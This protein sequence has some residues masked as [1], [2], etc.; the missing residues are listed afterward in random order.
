MGVLTIAIL[1][2][3]ITTGAILAAAMRADRWYSRRVARRAA[4]CAARRVPV[5]YPAIVREVLPPTPQLSETCDDTPA[6]LLDDSF[7]FE[8]TAALTDDLPWDQDRCWGCAKGCKYSDFRALDRN[9]LEDE[10]ALSFARSHALHTDCNFSAD[11]ADVASILADSHRSDR[12]RLAEAARFK[13]RLWNSQCAECCAYVR[14]GKTLE[15]VD[16]SQVAAEE[17]P[18]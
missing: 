15:Q 3:G 12:S 13:R 11:A 6:E 7:D 9:W 1:A 8:A 5:V 4:Q 14:A 18:F 10:K 2:A 17:L 16:P